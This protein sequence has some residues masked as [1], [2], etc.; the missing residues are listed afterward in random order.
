MSTK[1]ISYTIS[2]KNID[3]QYIFQQ[4]LLKLA[5]PFDKFHDTINIKHATIYTEVMYML[6]IIINY[7][8]RILGIMLEENVDYEEIVKE[9]QKLDEYINKK[10]EEL[11]V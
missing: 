11:V 6:D 7:H 2:K 4:K 1:I 9:S 5:N 3:S 10:M 8:K